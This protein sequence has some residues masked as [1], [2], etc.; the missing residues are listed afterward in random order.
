MTTGAINWEDK[1]MSVTPKPPHRCGYVAPMALERAEGGLR[2]SLPQVRDHGTGE[3]KVRR[4]AA[5]A[6]EARTAEPRKIGSSFS[7][8]GALPRPRRTSSRN[9]D[10]GGT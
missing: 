7:N 6:A 3:G 5:G 8:P 1:K 2:G 9:I 4:S 10:P